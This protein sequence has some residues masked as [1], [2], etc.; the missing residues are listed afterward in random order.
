MAVVDGHPALFHGYVDGAGRFASRDGGVGC[1]V[2]A[3]IVQR[4]D[5]LQCGELDTGEGWAAKMFARN[6]PGFPF[7]PWHDDRI[8]PRWFGMNC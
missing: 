1:G 2:R 8:H 3:V 5:A 4:V 7:W 6:V